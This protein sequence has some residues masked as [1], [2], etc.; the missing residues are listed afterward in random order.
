MQTMIESL[1]GKEDAMMK[2]L[3]GKATFN[4]SKKHQFSS[5][6]DLDDEDEDE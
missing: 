4:K 5:D 3:S 2:I 1:I 6:D